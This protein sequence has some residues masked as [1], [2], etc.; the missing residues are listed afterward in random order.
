VVIGG[1]LLAG[2]YPARSAKRTGTGT[3]TETEK[4]METE[5]ETENGR[6]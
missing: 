2:S 5:T 3:E 1:I 6:W 4:E